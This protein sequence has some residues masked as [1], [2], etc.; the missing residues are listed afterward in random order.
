M[1][2][3]GPRLAPKQGGRDP[4]PC[5]Y[6]ASHGKVARAEG[7]GSPRSIASAWFS[8]QRAKSIGRPKTAYSVRTVDMVPLV[9][10]IAS[11]IG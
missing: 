1:L 6:R 11:T 5:C 2:T 4:S 7:K 8:Y 9:R 3:P 10:G